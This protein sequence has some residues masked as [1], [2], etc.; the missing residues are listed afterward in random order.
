MEQVAGRGFGIEADEAGLSVVDARGTVWAEF[1]A[2]NP[3]AG[4]LAGFILSLARET[5]AEGMRDAGTGALR[6]LAL[7]R[8]R[9]DDG[10]RTWDVRIGGTHGPCLARDGR[11]PLVPRPPARARLMLAVARC[12]YDVAHT[13]AAAAEAA[14]PADPLPA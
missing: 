7:H 4:F 13:D 2:D 9:N 10:S 11:H 5:Y 8:G 6:T 12:V 1:G 14:E 3:H